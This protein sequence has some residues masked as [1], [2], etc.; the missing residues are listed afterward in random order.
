VTVALFDGV[1]LTVEASLSAATG[2]YGAWNSGVW[3][4]A[5]WGPGDIYVDISA[6]ARSLTSHRG[7]SRDIQAWDPGT[8]VVVLADRDR[9]FDPTNLSGP[10]VTAGVTQ[11]RPWRPLR[12]SAGFG[13][14]SYPVYAGYAL[15]WEKTFVPGH[16]DAYVTVSCE[17]ELSRLA[18]FDGLE[19]TPAGS[20]ELAGARIH[21]VLDN[22][23]H[24]GAR[25]ID[26]GVNTMQATNLSANCV[27]ELKLTADSEGGAVY[28]DPSGTIR[29]DGQTA[30]LDNVRSNTIQAT[31]D[32]GTAGGIPCA[33]VTPAYN[34]DLT[35]NIAAFARVGGTAQV[36]ADSTSR[37]LY[38]DRR[39]SRTDLVCETDAQALSL[40]SWWVARFKDPELRITRIRVLPR[41]D[42]VRMF[43]V[44]LGLR[45]RD[46]VRVTVRPI[47]GGVIT[48]DC[49]ISGITHAV[50]GDDWVT[51][52]DLVSAAFTQTYYTSKW[53]LATW[54]ASS[55]FF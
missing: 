46:L 29:F 3:D 18:S 14:V 35:F 15:A 20:G 5:T 48:Q 9:R 19:V 25:D 34:G 40:A 23:G 13:G 16:A 7:F 43:P 6:Y 24:A 47:G 36:A 51:D 2:T 11:V 39:Y 38:G 41:H 50:T 1:S 12:W 22:A 31:F 17:D 10:Y 45:I 21:R 42:P 28:V 32:D 54:D 49:H 37:A 30:L 27:T 26:V 8:S 55:W 33:D 4:T 52:L 53:D 44:A